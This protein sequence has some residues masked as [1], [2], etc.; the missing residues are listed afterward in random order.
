MHVVQSAP[1]QTATKIAPKIQMGPQ[2]FVEV[3]WHGG[4]PHGQSQ[5]F[6][7][8]VLTCVCLELGFRIPW[9]GLEQATP[10]DHRGSGDSTVIPRSQERSG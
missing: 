10:K 9:G 2:I 7:A 8:G 3:I 4:H 6:Q 5:V 1:P